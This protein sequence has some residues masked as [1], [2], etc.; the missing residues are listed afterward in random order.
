MKTSDRSE[1]CNINVKTYN[2]N[3]FVCCSF[4]V[5]YWCCFRFQS[6]YISCKLYFTPIYDK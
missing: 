1:E 3:V 6:K 5:V 2:I 4:F